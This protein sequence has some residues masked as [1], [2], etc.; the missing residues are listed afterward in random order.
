M[1][2]SP[3]LLIAVSLAGCATYEE[4]RSHLVATAAS[5]EGQP[6][7][8]AIDR[9]G[10]PSS[11]TP[12]GSSTIYVWSKSNVIYPG[13]DQPLSCEIR[14]LVNEAQIVTKGEHQGNNYACSEMAK[15]LR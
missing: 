6:L 13:L 5:L 8:A 12:A 3:A 15:G 9:L 11:T 14:L 1:R 10:V 4:D 2:T 7:S